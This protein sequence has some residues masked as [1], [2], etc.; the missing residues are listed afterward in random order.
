MMVEVVG[1][2]LD[3][4]DRGVVLALG[5]IGQLPALAE[6]NITVEA[7]GGAQQRRGSGAIVGDEG[8][9][10]GGAA[11]TDLQ[12][13]AGFLLATNRA[14][15]R[16]AATSGPL[17]DGVEVVAHQGFADGQ[18]VAP[19]GDEIAHDAGHVGGA[20]DGGRARVGQV[21]QLGQMVLHARQQ[22]RTIMRR[23][24]IGVAGQQL[25]TRQCVG[26]E[27]HRQLPVGLLQTT[28]ASG[29][30][31]LAAD[32]TQQSDVQS[33]FV[34]PRHDGCGVIGTTVVDDEHLEL[35]FKGLPGQAAQHQRQPRLL[36]VGGND[37]GDVHLAH[38]HS[39]RSRQSKRR[40]VRAAQGRWPGSGSATRLITSGVDFTDGDPF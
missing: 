26:V 31:A 19:G 12:Q 40:S 28:V 24:G 27:E 37:D 36:V 9:P 29:A 17:V 15:V 33:G 1:R 14:F 30:A 25:G 35:T 18:L 22:D 8:E 10:G 3:G 4:H 6:W 7:A 23:M 32:A 16:V 34:V 13:T 5:A 39:A 38:T 20:I 2:R 11:R 21:L